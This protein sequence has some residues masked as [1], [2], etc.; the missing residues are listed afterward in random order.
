MKFYEVEA[1][2]GHVGRN[3]Y[4]IKKFYI[5]ALDGKEAALKARKS[6][7]VKHHN[8]KAII[9]VTEIKY[10]DYVNG[11]NQMSQDPYFLVHSST[12]Q[13]RQCEFDENEIIREDCTQI[14]RKPTH[15]KRIKI[16]RMMEKDWK[17]GKGYLYE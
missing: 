17:S 5:C 11:L 8:K 15:A 14:L 2:C 7:R 6:P 12:E 1:R 13:R 10:E 9:S 16:R 3:N 4:I